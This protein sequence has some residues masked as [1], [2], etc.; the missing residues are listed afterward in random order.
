MPITQAQKAQILLELVSPF[1][2]ADPF[3]RG[4]ALG[5]IDNGRALFGVCRWTET[6][7]ERLLRHMSHPIRYDF[8]QRVIVRRWRMTTPPK[9]LLEECRDTLVFRIGVA[10]RFSIHTLPRIANHGPHWIPLTNFM[11]GSIH[12]D[13]I[14]RRLFLEWCWQCLPITGDY[15]PFQ[16]GPILH[17]TRT[18]TS[19]IRTFVIT[20]NHIY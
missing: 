8:T 18:N 19:D 3:A 13:R 6:E 1:L 5:F 15:H 11:A 16:P 4:T 7:K 20:S 12:F 2:V 9:M 14:T 17:G 10:Q